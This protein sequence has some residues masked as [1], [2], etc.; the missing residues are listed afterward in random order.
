MSISS[1]AMPKSV[2]VTVGMPSRSRTAIT[3]L[4]VAMVITTVVGLS[5]SLFFPAGDNGHLTYDSI[6]P[7]RTF[8]RIWL[9]L[10][11]VNLVIGAVV[12]SVAAWLLVPARGW[13]ATTIG[14]S[15]F[16]FGAALYAAGVGGIATLYYFVTDDAALNPAAG[17]GLI[18]SLDVNQ[19]ALWGPAFAGALVSLVGQLLLAAGLWRAG[20]VPRW[21]P[22]LAATVIATFVLPTSGLT[23]VLVELPSALAGLGLA[24]CLWRAHRETALGA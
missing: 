11:A 16:C 18:D 14:A 1:P 22:L 20:T 10:A 5:V 9:T 2:S 8:F 23:G 4:V 6:A 13:V 19:L 3:I 17:T 15:L 24:R 7:T 12:F 21:I